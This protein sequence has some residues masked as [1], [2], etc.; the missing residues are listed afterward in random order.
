VYG[1]LPTMPRAAPPTYD[2]M[3]TLPF[4]H[5]SDPVVKTHPL[6]H[7]VEHAPHPVFRLERLHARVT[8]SVMKILDP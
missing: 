8:D 5:Y 2:G 3:K 4:S 1:S 6:H 7:F